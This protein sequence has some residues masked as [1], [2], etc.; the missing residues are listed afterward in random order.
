MRIPSRPKRDPLGWWRPRCSHQNNL[1]KP[2]AGQKPGTERKSLLLRVIMRD[3][4]SGEKLLQRFKRSVAKEGILK[5]IKKRKFHE[6][7]SQA[8]RRRMREQEK[9][10]RKRARK[11]AARESR[12]KVPRF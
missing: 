8:R 4:E 6:K 10:L 1:E 5:E 2:R 12:R 7:P 3:G 11:A 9:L